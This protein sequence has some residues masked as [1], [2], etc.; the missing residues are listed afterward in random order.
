MAVETSETEIRVSTYTFLEKLLKENG[1]NK[2]T[3]FSP[4]I[5]KQ[6]KERGLTKTQLLKLVEILNASQSV[7]E[8]RT[9]LS[10]LARGDLIED[11]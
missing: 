1:W 10:A 7:F 2:K 11:I 6:F 4:D 3:W 9:K 5:E 8:E